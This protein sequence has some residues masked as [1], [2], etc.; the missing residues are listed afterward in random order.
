MLAGELTDA[1]LRAVVRGAT[2][3]IM[4]SVYEGFGFPPLEAM[5]AGCATIVSRSA[6]LPE[7]CGDAS[8]YFDALDIRGLADAM[9]TLSRDAEKRR[10]MVERGR[11]HARRFDWDVSARNTL[12]V[13]RN[14]LGAE[15]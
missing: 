5:A 7:V 11:I 10:E 9:L 8:I 12:A 4:P 1:Q 13:I 6:S 14:T 3:L 15:R 2:A